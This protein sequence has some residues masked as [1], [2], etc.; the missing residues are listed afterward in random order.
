MAMPADVRC[1]THTCP[2][3]SKGVFPR[4]V[5][6]ADAARHQAQ[7]NHVT[8][9]VHYLLMS[10]NGRRTLL[11]VHD[12]ATLER[13]GG[14]KRAAFKLIWYTLPVRRAGLVSVVS[15]ATR[16]ELLRHVHCDPAKIRVI[17]NC[18]ASDF[19][20]APKKF[21][22][23]DPE[24]LHLGTAANKNLERVIEA[25]AGLRCHLNIIGTLTTAQRALLE[26]QG[27]RHSNIPRATDAE[28]VR[29][30]QACDMVVFASAYEGFGLPI[31][32]ANATGRPVVTSDLLSMPEVAGKAACLVDPYDCASIRTGVLRVWRD[33]AYRDSL[34][35]AGLE[36]AKRFT[37][38]AVA[39]K[40]ASL[41]RELAAQV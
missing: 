3:F 23:S 4:L 25:L 11:T 31:V 20:P 38:K 35:Q 10:L 14:L 16:R 41:Y 34:V 15:E 18:V 13:L 2:R 24:L 12:C 29:A 1:S 40:Y 39:E 37:P 30:Y 36:N 28:V 6:M 19:V 7:V 8:G 32:E 26:Q 9:D 33:A 21:N 5:N 22:D 27:I 17:H